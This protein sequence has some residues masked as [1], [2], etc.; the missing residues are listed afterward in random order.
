MIKGGYKIINLKD[1][2]LVPEATAVIIEGLY[3][4]IANI[5][6]K[7]LL[8]SGIVIDGVKKA[9]C[10]VEAKITDT[11]YHIQVY[12]YDIAVTNEDAVTIT[13]LE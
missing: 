13:V 3:N 2:D 8:L 7:V 10:F 1:T 12:G 4:S 11:T 6:R 5:Y 9:D